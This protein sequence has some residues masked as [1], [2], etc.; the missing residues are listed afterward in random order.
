MS[1][2]VGQKKVIAHL[3]YRFDIGGLERVMVNCINAMPECDHVIIALTEASD[4]AQH[5][6]QETP[7]YA[8]NKSQGKDLGS[9]WRLLGLLRKVKPNVLHTYNLAAI[10]YHPI[11]YLAGVKGHIHAEHGRE[12]SDPLGLNTKHNFLRRLMS[13]FIDHYVAVSTDLQHWLTDVVEILPKKVT[14]I[15]NGIDTSRFSPSYNE[16]NEKLGTVKSSTVNFIHVARLNPV[17]DQQNLINAFAQLSHQ[18]RNIHLTVVGD[19]ELMDM[20]TELSTSLGIAEKV[21]FTGARDDI[22]NLLNAADVFVLSSI[23][24][25]IPMTVLEAMASG[26]PVIST[27]VG[28]LSELITE[29]QTGKLVPAEQSQAL[30]SAMGDYVKYP[31][32]ITLHGKN[33]QHFI[34][35]NFSEQSMIKAYQQLYSSSLGLN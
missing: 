33:A 18:Y 35:D 13:P 15:R 25:G 6:N 16:D 5:L 30:A 12:V 34:I 21:T 27:N 7:V 22:A 32:N 1:L 24:E 11:A 31:E 23:A 9:H 8:L 2:L 10:E 28:G 4:F 17:K 3:I 14:L 19:G 29:N 26:L 20:L